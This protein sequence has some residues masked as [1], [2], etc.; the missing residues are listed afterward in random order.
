LFL[1]AAPDDA[2]VRRRPPLEEVALAALGL[3]EHELLVG[4]RVR[5]R[6]PRC[7]AARADVDDGPRQPLDQ[8]DS[9][10]RVLEQHAPRLAEVP[11]RGQTG[12]LDDGAQPAAKPLVRVSGP[13]EG[14]RGNREVPPAHRVAK[15]TTYRFGSTPSLVVSTPG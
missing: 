13:G 7:A 12:R 15:T 11:Q 14:A 1:G 4:Q 6:D 5:E 9:A 2:R 10:Q 8:L 3:D